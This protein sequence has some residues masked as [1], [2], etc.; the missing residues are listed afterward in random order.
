MESVTK[1]LGVT[2]NYEKINAES[3]LVSHVCSKNSAKIALVES[4][5]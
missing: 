4:G 3:M 1:Y 2:K 5:E